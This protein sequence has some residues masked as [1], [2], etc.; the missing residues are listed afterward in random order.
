MSVCEAFSLL[1]AAEIRHKNI[2]AAKTAT[3]HRG[4]HHAVLGSAANTVL[5]L[6]EELVG[7]IHAAEPAVDEA[8]LGQRRHPHEFA[9]A[10]KDGINCRRI[11]VEAGAWAVL[12]LATLIAGAAGAR[13]LHALAFPLAG[14]FPDPAAF[15]RLLREF[16]EDSVVLVEH[17]ALPRPKSALTGAT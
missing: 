13:R 16:A 4:G 10:G 1:S 7:Q 12:V 6:P 11:R 3:I 5:V 2:G 8:A 9:Q 17:G 14:A 15:V